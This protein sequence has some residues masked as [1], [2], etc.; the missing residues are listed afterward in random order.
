MSIRFGRS[1]NGYDSSQVMKTAD[2]DWRQITDLAERR[3]IQNR[4]AQRNYRRKLR[5]RLEELERQAGETSSVITTAK[6]TTTKERSNS[7]GS[8]A[9]AG[10]VVKRSRANSA[11]SVRS[12]PSGLI[13]QVPRPRSAEPRSATTVSDDSPLTP[14][15]VGHFNGRSSTRNYYGGDF[16][17]LFSTV[18]TQPTHATAG[19][20]QPQWESQYTQVV[21]HDASLYPLSSPSIPASSPQDIRPIGGYCST[22]WGMEYPALPS[23]Y[24]ANPTVNPN[25]FHVNPPLPR[26]HFYLTVNYDKLVNATVQVGKI[27]N[28]EEADMFKEEALSPFHKA[29]PWN[30]PENAE[31]LEPTPRQLEVPHHPWIDII[32]FKGLRDSL[33]DYAEEGDRTGDFLDEERVC[34][35]MHGNIGVWGDSPWDSRSYE[36]SEE[37]IR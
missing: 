33:L 24:S 37:F 10:R 27:L 19:G 2:D 32:P 30:I 4:L 17:P 13:L 26:D 31:D 1:G 18:D 34:T 9:T 22:P 21:N 28:I 3:K 20:Y 35:A 14:T 7:T 6:K 25:P 36:A 23:T 5:E 15:T 11:R 8:P 16:G 12:N 29:E